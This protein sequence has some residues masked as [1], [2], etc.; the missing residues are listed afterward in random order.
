M[1]KVSK[2]IGGALTGFSAALTTAASDGGIVTNEWWLIL[3][4][5][6]GGFALVWSAPANTA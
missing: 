4:S 6:V 2:A 3:A 5:T 1:Q